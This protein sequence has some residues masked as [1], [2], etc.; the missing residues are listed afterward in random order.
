MD[1][2]KLSVPM[3]IKVFAILDCYIA[4]KKSES[5]IINNTVKS[6]ML[7][8]RE[9]TTNITKESD[10]IYPNYRLMQY[11]CDDVKS[12]F[13]KKKPTIGDKEK[14]LSM[15]LEKSPYGDL[16]LISM[17]LRGLI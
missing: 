12:E 5:E 17:L 6:I 8:I 10:K 3:A 4:F 1:M 11:V 15:I 14:V 16:K 7:D 2:T 13:D 9:H